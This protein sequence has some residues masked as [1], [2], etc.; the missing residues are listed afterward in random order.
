MSLPNLNALKMFDAAAR[1][2]NFRLAAD[3]LH[4]TQGAVAQQVRRLEADLGVQLFHRKARGLLL[5]EDGRRYHDPV[6]RAL[7]LIED[8]TQQ[9]KPEGSQIILSVPPSFA[10]KWL[11]PRMTDL[12]NALPGLDIQIVASEALADFRSDGVDIAVRQGRCPSGAG[13]AVERLSPI[14]LCAVASPGYAASIDPIRRIEDFCNYALIQDGHFHWDKLFQASGSKPHGRVI[15]L[16]QTALA[17]D[18]ASNGQ[19]IAL[20]P[21][22]FLEQERR[23]HSLLEIWSDDGRNE[24]GFYV[25]WLNDTKPSAAKEAVID[26]LL[27]QCGT[28]RP[29]LKRRRTAVNKPKPHPAET[30][31]PDLAGIENGAQ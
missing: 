17:M 2:L 1:H 8:A 21:R 16:N 30:A 10:A 9:L 22:L 15:Q 19:G 14:D 18:A 11:V 24:S 27:S 3:E 13:F 31:G 28:E 23:R 29:E 12:S 20:V 25:V 5:T 4:V 7:A 26:W 6:R